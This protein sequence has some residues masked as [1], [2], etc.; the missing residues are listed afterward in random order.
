MIPSV[1][2][3]GGEHGPT[4]ARAQPAFDGTDLSYTLSGEPGAIQ[5]RQSHS[6]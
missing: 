5:Q 2:S 4:K 1:L 3:K 6:C